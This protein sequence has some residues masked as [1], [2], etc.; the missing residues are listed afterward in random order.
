MTPEQISSEEPRLSDLELAYHASTLIEKFKEVIGNS[1]GFK[2]MLS[3]TYFSVIPGE[4]KGLMNNP[5]PF[6]SGDY[7]YTVLHRVSNDH[8]HKSFRQRLQIE[9]FPLDKEN[10]GNLERITLLTEAEEIGEQPTW[11]RIT[12]AKD[13]LN[14]A[15]MDYQCNTDTVVEKAEEVLTEFSK[16]TDIKPELTSQTTQEEKNE[17]NEEE[18]AQEME[19]FE[20]KLI[21]Y[22]NRFLIHT[23]RVIDP[24]SPSR[25]DRMKEI[26]VRC[27][28]IRKA[29]RL[30]REEVA[31]MMDID[32]VQLVAFERGL[33]PP[34]DLPEEFAQKLSTILI[35][36]IMENP[37]P[38]ATT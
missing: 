28:D 6:Q 15:P 26:G 24:A 36:K 13:P 4:V 9:K 10:K 8:K 20:E 32:P 33:I 25:P 16:S 38:P 7:L 37:E 2:E 22:Y 27:R 34:M 30:K 12:Y 1:P 21:P 5:I 31:R 35:E 11:G 23:K 17:R 14:A 19:Q 18:I 3:R 29:C